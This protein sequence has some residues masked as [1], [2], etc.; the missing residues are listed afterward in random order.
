ME[1]EREYFLELEAFLDGEYRAAQVFPPR[2]QVFKALELTSIRRVRVVV[3]GQDPYHQP[4]QAHGLAFSVPRG[5]TPPP[6]LRNLFREL[7]QDTGLPIPDLGNLEPWAREGVL[8]L[9]TVLTVRAGEPGSHAGK[10]WEEFTDRVIDLVNAN[11]GRTVF[12]LLGSQA[13]KK[14]HRVDTAR[15][16]IIEAPHPSPLSARRGFFGSRIFSRTNEL[17]ERAGRGVVDWAL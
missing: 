11:R 9:N 4:G 5:I 16:A 8:L 17:L 14:G 10:G 6:S 12:L 15:H 7:H 1:R 3:L 2:Q 13:Q